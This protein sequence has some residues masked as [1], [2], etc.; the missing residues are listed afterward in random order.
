MSASRRPNHCSSY[1][2][3][4]GFPITF[5]HRCYLLSSAPSDSHLP[6]S[7]PFLSPLQTKPHDTCSSS[8][9]VWFMESPVMQS[10]GRRSRPPPPTRPYSR[11]GLLSSSRGKEA[12]GARVMQG[13]HET[14]VAAASVVPT[15]CPRAPSF[16][17]DRFRDWNCCPSRLVFGPS[18]ARCL[19]SSH[20][21]RISTGG[22]NRVELVWNGTQKHRYV[23]LWVDFPI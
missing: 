15:R 1:P 5:G 7:I 9:T 18:P 8:A 10:C 12:F 20:R 22:R 6:P 3:L 11:L 19:F 4:P 13:L 2:F 17:Q 23:G 21:K 16:R 14:G